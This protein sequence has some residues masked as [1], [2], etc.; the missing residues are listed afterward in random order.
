MMIIMFSGAFLI[1]YVIMLCL[2]G[3]PLF[4]MEL[5]L[6]QFSGLGPVSAWRASPAFK[7]KHPARH[8][9]ID[10]AFF[11]YLWCVIIAHTSMGSFNQIVVGLNWKSW[12]RSHSS[13][14]RSCL[15]SI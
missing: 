13:S 15:P 3:I 10:M 12:T 1:P 9:L 4:L 14:D 5:T 2:A 6:G 8:I 7:G 11:I